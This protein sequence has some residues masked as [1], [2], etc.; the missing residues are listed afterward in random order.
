MKTKA[1]NVLSFVSIG[2]SVN[3]VEFTAEEI[4]KLKNILRYIDVDE[5]QDA[6]VIRNGKSRI[7]VREDGTLRIEGEKVTHTSQGT[8]HLS[9]ALIEIN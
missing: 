1:D 9:A 8:L 4:A 3:P 5:N 6:L 2:E 7:L